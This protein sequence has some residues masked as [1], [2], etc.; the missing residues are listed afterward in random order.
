MWRFC[1]ISSILISGPRH[2]SNGPMFY[3]FTFSWTQRCSS[4]LLINFFYFKFIAISLK[5][6]FS[7]QA[8]VRSE[9]SDVLKKSSG[10]MSHTEIQQLH[11][12]EMCI[13]ESLRLYPSVPFI[14]RKITKDLQLSEKSITLSKRSKLMIRTFLHTFF[15]FRKSPYTRRSN[16][17]HAYL[18]FTQRWKFLARAKQIH[19]REVF[20]C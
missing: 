18:R 19:S 13:K 14:A 5:K 3:P 17:K 4:K 10:K 12:L 1:I 20:A 15:T 11:Y 6:K 7:K 2:F 9:I 8:K 16:C